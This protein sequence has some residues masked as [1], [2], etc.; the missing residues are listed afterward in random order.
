MP[1]PE[2][3]TSTAGVGHVPP[4]S[5]GVA[6]R[7]IGGGLSCLLCAV[8]EGTA[9][10]KTASGFE[11]FCWLLSTGAVFGSV[12][13]VGW[14]GRTCAGLAAGFSC[15]GAIFAP[16]GSASVGF[17]CSEA[18]GLAP[19]GPV[20]TAAGAKGRAAALGSAKGTAPCPTQTQSPFISPSL[21]CRL[22]RVG[23]EVPT[24]SESEPTSWLGW[25]G[26]PT[27]D[28]FSEAASA[29]VWRVSES[30][31]TARLPGEASGLS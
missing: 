24:M 26:C 13:G 2:A 16:A 18:D 8:F 7:I 1:A 17:N 31:E 20:W 10:P 6:S 4:A 3:K 25:V 28:G 11:G 5:P 22:G 19:A 29:S 9:V 27:A 30:R 21:F 14:V 23:A 12:G 15:A